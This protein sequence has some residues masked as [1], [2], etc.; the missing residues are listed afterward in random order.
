M[1]SVISSGVKG[2]PGMI[3]LFPGFSPRGSRSQRRK[4]AS[5]L[6]KML[7]ANVVRDAKWVRFGPIRLPAGVPWMA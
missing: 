4:L 7:P 5:L 3:I 6:S 1:S 2:A